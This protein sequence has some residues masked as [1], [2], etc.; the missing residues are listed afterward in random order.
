M[1][2]LLLYA[3]LPALQPLQ[4][5]LP[6]L[7]PLWFLLPHLLPLWF[8]LPHLLPLW[9]LLLHLYPR[10]LPRHPAPLLSYYPQFPLP[11]VRFP[12]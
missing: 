5:L 9:F 3:L 7:P 2:V 8:L 4:F 11:P 12:E 10:L 6:H 1:P